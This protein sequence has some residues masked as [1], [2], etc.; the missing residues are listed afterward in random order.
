MK[1]GNLVVSS[2]FVILLQATPYGAANGR[3][4]QTKGAI[5]DHIVNAIWSHGPSPT[6]QNKDTPKLLRVARFQIC[7]LNGI[8][9]IDSYILKMIDFREHG[10]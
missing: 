8:V 4:D 5:P 10:L 6:L 2:V 3:T 7:I 9:C 1:E